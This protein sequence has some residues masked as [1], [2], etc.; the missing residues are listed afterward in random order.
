M[1]DKYERSDDSIEETLKKTHETMGLL[2]GLLEVL[3]S[4]INEL[5][6]ETRQKGVSS[7]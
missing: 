2:E 7:S 1:P 4:Q 5:Q 3:T 6:S